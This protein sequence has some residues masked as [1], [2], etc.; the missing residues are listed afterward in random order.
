M[1]T[2]LFLTQTPGGTLLNTLSTCEPMNL[3]V[4]VTISLTLT[5]C[6]FQLPLTLSFFYDV[7][8]LPGTISGFPDIQHFQL[9]SL[10][11]DSDFCLPVFSFNLVIFTKKKKKMT[12]FLPPILTPLS[13][14]FL[15]FPLFLDHY[16]LSI[17]LCSPPISHFLLSLSPRLYVYPLYSFRKLLNLF[18]ISLHRPHASFTLSLSISLFGLRFV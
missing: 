16:S 6:I 9:R 14:Y 17:H 7:Y 4:N 2:E 5:E 8:R 12:V 15:F 13:F 18:S 1:T 10:Y 3:A 11:F